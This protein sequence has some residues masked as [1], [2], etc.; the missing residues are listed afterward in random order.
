[1]IEHERPGRNHVPNIL[2]R[3]QI[4]IQ[5]LKVFLIQSCVERFA[6]TILLGFARVDLFVFDPSEGKKAI[7]SAISEFR[8]DGGAEDEIGRPHIPGKLWLGKACRDT[9]TDFS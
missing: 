9:R 4:H 2:Q 6:E 8:P 3:E 1:M 7:E 5:G